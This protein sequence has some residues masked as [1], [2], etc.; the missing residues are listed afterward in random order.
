V[1]ELS[2]P[3][4]AP[5]REIA[6]DL[7]RRGLFAGPVLV[8]VCTIAWGADGLVSSLFAVVLV[9]VNFLAGAW[10]IDWAVKI[11]PQMLMAAVLGGFL[12][13]MGVLTAAVLPVR[14][15]GWFEVAAFALTLVVAHLGLLAWETRFVS[16]TLAHPGLEPGTSFGPLARRRT[17]QGVVTR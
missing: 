10:I 5:E 2:A 9:L 6:V 15:A 12:I 17:R 14:N 1:A 4:G 13:R 16:A 8:A 11:S 7:F 3:A